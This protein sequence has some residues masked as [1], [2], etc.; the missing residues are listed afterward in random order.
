[1]WFVRSGD[2]VNW[3]D[4]SFPEALTSESF[5]SICASEIY[6]KLSIMFFRMVTYDTGKARQHLCESGV[7]PLAIPEM[8]WTLVE[9]QR[10]HQSPWAKAKPVRKGSP[11]PQ[12]HCLCLAM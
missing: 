12:V 9:A 1:M 4:K 10:T 6:F 11:Q 3:T 8:L 2:H 7:E 5:Q